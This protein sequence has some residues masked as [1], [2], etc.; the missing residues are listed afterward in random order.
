M[1]R[2]FLT[3]MMLLWVGACSSSKKVDRAEGEP[4]ELSAADDQDILNTIQSVPQGAE[5]VGLLTFADNV[6][7]GVEVKNIRRSAQISSENPGADCELREANPG[8][9]NCVK[10][11]VS[12]TIQERKLSNGKLGI[13]WI[14][15]LG[16]GKKT[17]DRWGSELKAAGFV[18]VPGA[19]SKTAKE[20]TWIFE[21]GGA[22]RATFVYTAA[23]E[24]ISVTLEAQK[25]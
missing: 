12:L 24:K 5:T 7:S 23:G 6:V 18:I 11:G 10:N 13:A 25:K 22:S 1:N 14:K 9:F 20:Q 2:W 19:G 17:R 3:S 8:T 16:K 21:G 15:L 4:A